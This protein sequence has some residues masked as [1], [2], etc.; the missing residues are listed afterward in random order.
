MVVITMENGG[1]IKLELDAAARPQDGGKLSAA[2][3]RRL[4]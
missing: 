4:L 2:G 1:Q 3:Q